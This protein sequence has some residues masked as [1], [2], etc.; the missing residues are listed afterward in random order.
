MM[1]A[2]L[3]ES[4]TCIQVEIYEYVWRKFCLKT[5]AMCL[6]AFRR[7]RDHTEGLAVAQQCVN[8]NG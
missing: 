3:Q 7:P 6:A 2:H 8:A 5:V 4:Q 1:D